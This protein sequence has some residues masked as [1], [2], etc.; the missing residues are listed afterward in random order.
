M[1]PA[2]RKTCEFPGCV[3]TPPTTEDGVPTPFVTS[4]ENQTKAEVS[5]E[6]D[7]H[8]ERAHLLH[9]RLAENA[10]KAREAEARNGEAEAQVI[11]AEAAKIRET[12]NQI[13]ATQQKSRSSS[14]VSGDTNPT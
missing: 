4:V 14:P 11:Q 5:E 8:I 2:T 7:K 13:L 12:T 3:S 6:M 10:T 1:P 9:L